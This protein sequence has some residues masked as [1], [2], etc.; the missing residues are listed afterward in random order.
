D[1]KVQTGQVIWE[2]VDETKT[3]FV[4]LNGRTIGNAASGA[5]ER[6]NADTEDL[7]TYY[8]N[9]MSDTQ[10]PV[11]GGRGSTAAADY[12]ANKTITLLN[13]R[14]AMLC[15]LSDMGNSDSGALDDAPAT[16]GDGTTPGSILGANTH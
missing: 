16:N 11:S 7:F 9:K 6:A 10:A 8:W 14:G 4:R 3:G 12:A 1:E 13:G 5:T 15:G 2:P